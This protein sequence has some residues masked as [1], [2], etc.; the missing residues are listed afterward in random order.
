MFKKYI[1]IFLLCIS[2]LLLVGH[3]IVPHHHPSD[4]SF[5]ATFEHTDH[6][7]HK[8]HSDHHHGHH[9]HGHQDE[10]HNDNDSGLNDLF[11]FMNHASDYVRNDNELPK[12]EQSIQ[13]VHID[14]ALIS[15]TQSLQVSV[16]CLKTKQLY[17][18]DPDYYPPPNLH[19]GLR[20]PPVF[21]S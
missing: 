5:E 3:S 8:H 20:A 9:H 1:A 17:Y 15:S 16:S 11:A 13:E 10:D 7:N 4:K 14:T 21:F 12:F 2:N 18:R 19:K 6:E